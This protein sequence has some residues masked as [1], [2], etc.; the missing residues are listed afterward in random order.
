MDSKTG[1]HIEYRV[2]NKQDLPQISE[3]FASAF[4]ESLEHY[5]GPDKLSPLVMADAFAACLEAQPEAFFVATVDNEVV[6]YVFAPT[7][8][9][10][11]FRVFLL[12]GHF[13]RMLRRWVLG[14]Y[15][16]GFRTA[17]LATWNSIYMATQSRKSIQQGDA[18]ILSIAVNPDR[19]GLGIGSTLMKIAMEYLQ[20]SGAKT[21]RLEVRADNE[22]A[23]HIYEKNGFKVVGITRDTQAEWVIMAKDLQEGT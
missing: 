8:L 21:V 16:I 18:R 1:I 5:V 22:P 13:L 4:P 14:H 17:L 2:A 6:G 15:G 7:N 9:S 23:I 20:S 12:H 3:V 10:R 11:V 19:Q